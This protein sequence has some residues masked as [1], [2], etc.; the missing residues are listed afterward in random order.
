[1]AKLFTDAGLIVIAAFV[2]PF[3]ADRETARSLFAEG[4]FLEVFVDMPPELAAERDTKGLYAKARGGELQ[5]LTGL[6][7][8][9]E[10][11]ETPELRLEMEALSLDEAAERVVEALRERS[12]LDASVFGRRTKAP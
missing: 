7:S 5:N 1:M 9:Y 12:L 4:E 10:P 2:S 8:V 11:P 3:R 6:G